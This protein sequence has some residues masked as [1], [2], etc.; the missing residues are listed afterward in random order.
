MAEFIVATIILL[1]RKLGDSSINIHR[2]EWQK[3]SDGCH[4][5]RGK[6]LGIV[7][8]GHGE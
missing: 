2:G 6:T 7:G 5:V 1:A 3:V 4:E 8:Y